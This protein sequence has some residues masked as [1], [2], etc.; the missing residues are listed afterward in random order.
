MHLKGITLRRVA[1][2][3]PE[4][5]FVLQTEILIQ[6][7]AR[8]TAT[9][10]ENQIKCAYKRLADTTILYCHLSK[11]N[12][13]VS[14]IGLGLIF[15]ILALIIYLTI[16]FGSLESVSKLDQI[17]NKFPLVPVTKSRLPNRTES[18]N[19]HV[20]QFGSWKPTIIEKNLYHEWPSKQCERVNGNPSLSDN[21]GIYCCLW[22]NIAD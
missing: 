8:V 19:I 22:R 17:D 5:W 14:G 13:K 3:L 7:K 21:V 4:G 16:A 9:T 11:N 1:L 12:R 6:T 15:L 10:V 20:W 2:I 18:R